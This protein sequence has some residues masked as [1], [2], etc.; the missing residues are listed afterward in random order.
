MDQAF[1]VKSMTL[2]LVW[3]VKIFIL[4]FPWKFYEL[5]FYI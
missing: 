3:V 4:F 1:G 2:H 5:M